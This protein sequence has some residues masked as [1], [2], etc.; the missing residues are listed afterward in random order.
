MAT[1]SPLAT[2]GTAAAPSGA[3]C[4]LC[5]T[6]FPFSTFHL[7]LPCAGTLPLPGLTPAAK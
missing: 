6:F 1:M 2:G 3:T 4:P 7:H 5:L